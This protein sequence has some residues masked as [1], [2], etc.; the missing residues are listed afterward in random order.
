VVDND[1]GLLAR[2]AAS[3]SPGVRVTTTPI[4]LARDLE[5]ALDGA[6]DLVTTSAL[7]DLV[8]DDWLER[9]T[10]EARAAPA[11]LCGVDL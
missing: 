8:S 11:G 9:L 7:L 2:A 10:I 5:L 6:V 3:A 1:L 4:D